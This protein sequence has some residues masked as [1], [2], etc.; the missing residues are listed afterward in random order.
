MVNEMKYRVMVKKYGYAEVEAANE[1]EARKKTDNMWDGEF[2]W[3]E[4]D[5]H[6]SKIVDQLP[7]RVEYTDHHGENDYITYFR[8]VEEA[9]AFIEKRYGSSNQI[10]F[11][12]YQL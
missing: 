4:R 12:R 9:K 8:T 10:F 7:V 11:Q 3:S 6:D 5:W 1:E 2:D